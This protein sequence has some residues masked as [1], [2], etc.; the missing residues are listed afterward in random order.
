MEKSFS[1]NDSER[2]KRVLLVGMGADIGSNLLYLCATTDVAYP[3]TDILTHP[4]ESEGVGAANRNSLDELQARLLLANPLLINKICI[5]S[6]RNQLIING[7][8]FSIHFCDF[9][10]EIDLTDLGKFELAVLATSRKHIRSRA[11]LNKLESI[12]RIVIGVAENSSLP[13]I[14]PALLSAP[15]AHFLAGRAVN[16]NELAGSFAMGSCQ[17]VGWTAGI[18]ILADYCA[19]QEV[20]L[21]DVLIHTE[22]DIIHPDTASSN[23]GTVRIGSRTED[24]RDN[25]RPGVSQVADSM[26]RFP[27]STSMNSVSLRVLSQPPGY[28]IQRFFLRGINVSANELIDVAKTLETIEPAIVYVTDMPV[29]SRVYSSLPVSMVLI[30]TEQHLSIRRIGDVVEVI[31][32]AYIHN[33]LGYCAAI[34]SATDR[35]LC[36]GNITLIDSNHP[37]TSEVQK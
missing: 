28:Q 19:R 36:G 25:L 6:Y 11:C 12:A 4:I 14:Y 31:I 34:L 9:N 1:K 27:P 20:R 5:D 3:I 10:T 21:H 33:T 7:R 22:I 29:G 18:R 16:S 2:K 8:T 26:L 13:A 30:A 23:F 24:P 32:Q 15:T 37:T 35:I 17:C